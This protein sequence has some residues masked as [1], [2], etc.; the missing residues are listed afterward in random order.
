M[1]FPLGSQTQVLTV[2]VSVTQG[3]VRRSFENL[4]QVDTSIHRGNSGGPI[5]G[6]NGKVIGIAS[7]VATEMASG[8]LPVMTALSDIGMVLPINKA[9][10]FLD[11]LK[12]GKMKW[13]GTLDLSFEEKITRIKEKATEGDWQGALEFA[14]NEVEKSRHPTILMFSAIMAFC[15][16]DWKLAKAYF[17]ETL[18]VDKSNNYARLLI[19]IIDWMNGNLKQSMHGKRLLELDW[20]SPDEFIGFLANIIDE[21][22]PL[23]NIQKG[24]DNRKEKSWIQYILALKEFKKGN[25]KKAEIIVK[26]VTLIASI[27]DWVF[28]LSRGTLDKIQEKRLERM[29]IAKFKSGYREEIEDF[30]LK[31]SQSYKKKTEKRNEIMPKLIKL[32]LDSIEIKEKMEIL[33]DMHSLEHDN[34]EILTGLVF[35]HAMGANWSKALEYAQLYLK[36]EGRENANRLSIGLME[37]GIMINMGRREESHQ[38]LSD[39]IQRT[40]DPWY[41]TI[42]TYLMEKKEWESL[43]QEADQSPQNLI[44]AHTAYGLWAESEKDYQRAKKHYREA[45][46]SYLDNWLEYDFAKERFRRIKMEN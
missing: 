14:R 24:W 35:F 4:L 40:K 41:R 20:R 12:Q 15:N 8:P 22:I 33:E 2:N 21:R 32:S 23:V 39:F 37:S 25:Y 5:I 10:S 3:N 30:K 9:T 18:S 46:G 43:A 28:Y 29:K 45:L 7:G 44:I 42:S 27:D 34:G 38:I 16:G 13:N 19:Y 11:D 1:G 36:K 26:E 6:A 31:L 17:E